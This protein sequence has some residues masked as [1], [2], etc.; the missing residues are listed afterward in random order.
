MVVWLVFRGFPHGHMFAVQCIPSL[1]A[2]IH[3]HPY[4]KT[5][6]CIHTHGSR[7]CT[8]N[9][10]QWISDRADVSSF[11]GKAEYGNRPTFGRWTVDGYCY[12]SVSSSSSSPSSSSNCIHIVTVPAHLQL[13]AS[14]QHILPIEPLPS[15]TKMAFPRPKPTTVCPCPIFRS[16]IDVQRRD[17]RGDPARPHGRGV[18]RRCRPRQ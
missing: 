4:A 8:M 1:L 18:G 2:W 11:P 13:I 6:Q 5:M 16:T 17:R 14:H 3:R 7:R 15:Y 10:G 12:S 9:D